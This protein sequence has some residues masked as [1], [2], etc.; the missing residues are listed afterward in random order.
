MINI[1]VIGAQF[2]DE[3]KGKIVDYLSENASLVVRFQGG[4][5]A[6]HTV[7]IGDDVF[8]LHHIP[9]GICR[10]KKC[11]LGNGVV[12]N[13][14]FLLKEIESLTERG[15]NLDGK[16][17]ISERAHII[18]PEHMKRDQKQEDARAQKVGTTGKGIGPSYTDKI[19]RHGIR[20]LDFSENNDLIPEYIP[21]YEK[22]KPYIANT[23]DI[24]H[25]AIEKKENLLFEG[26]QGTFLDVDHGTY[27]YVT[28]SNTV[29]GGACTGTGV[30]PTI[31]NKVIGVLKA[32]TT[33][34]GNGPFPCELNDETGDRLVQIG[35]EYGTTTGRRRRCGWLDL[36][37]ANYSRKINGITDWA[38][39]KLDV[40]SDFDEIKVCT[41]YK[42][43]GKLLSFFPASSKVLEQVEP[44]YETFKGWKTDLSKFQSFDKLPEETKEYLMFIEFYT[45]VPL[46]IV[47]YGPERNQNFILKNV[48]D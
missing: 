29:S 45:K 5:N 24:L 44:V 1:V 35:K 48:W 10:G 4:N 34:V 18:T 27:P 21:L 15:Y 41:G 13:P 14:D 38:I 23:F 22:L 40:L 46:S 47:S 36:F 20:F 17:F 39:T 42:Y 12:V 19:S 33:R 7:V 11:V 43:Q 28:S 30:P 9:S 26:A 3:G 8:K 2:G 6:G 31:I 32:Y 25:D 16:L 37:M